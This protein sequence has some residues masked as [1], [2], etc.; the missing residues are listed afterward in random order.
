MNSILTTV[1]DSKLTTVRLWML[2]LLVE[3]I[4]TNYSVHLVR[5]GVLLVVILILEV[6]S[7]SSHRTLWTLHKIVSKSEVQSKKK[8]S[9]SKKRMS[10]VKKRMSEVKKEC[11]K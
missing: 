11:Q 7:R 2:G 9:K 3:G 5:G 1:V 6:S 10:E 8:T 4:T